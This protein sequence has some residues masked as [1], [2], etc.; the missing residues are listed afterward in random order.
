[1]ALSPYLA[2]LRAHVGTD[3]LVVPGV[4]AIL[5]DAEGRV[6]VQKRTD[7]GRWGLPGGAIDP[8]ESPAQAVVREVLEELHVHVRPTA[9]LGVFGGEPFRHYYPHGDVVEYV[10]SVF[11]CELLPGESPAASTEETAQIAYYFP[12]ELPALTLPYPRSLFST[13]PSAPALFEW[14]EVSPMAP[15]FSA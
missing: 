3:L 8:G 5:R 11:L 13:L 9:L 14:D 1:M 15:A 4:S 10:V 6:L 12:E 2:K 7:D